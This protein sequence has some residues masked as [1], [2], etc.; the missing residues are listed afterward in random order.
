L[1]SASLNSTSSFRFGMSKTIVSPSR[2]GFRRDVPG[3]Q[4]ARGSRKPPVRHH[5]HGLAETGAD[6]GGRD[7][8]HL[9]HARPALRALAANDDDVA[10][11]NLVAEHR[12]ERGL[13]AVEDAR[14]AAMMLQV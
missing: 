12:V 3:H 6:D 14:R 10:R 1:S 9:G 7:G 11:T 4:P 13:L 5:D 2:I 8:Q